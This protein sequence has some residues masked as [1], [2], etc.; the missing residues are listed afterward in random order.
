MCRFVVYKGPKVL[1][2]SI[3]HD[4][5]HSIVNQSKNGGYHPGCIDKS[6]ERN[7]QV[8][9][10]GF[11]V[12]W[13]SYDAR[14]I[15]TATSMAAIKMAGGGGAAAAELLAEKPRSACVFRSTAP[16]WAN[17]NLRALVRHIDSGLIFAHVRAVHMN[18]AKSKNDISED[19]CHPFTHGRYTLMH[20]GCIAGFGGWKRAM[21]RILP[22][23]IYD[24]INGN[25][26]SEHAF[27]LLLD[28]IGADGN[29]ER[30]LTAGEFASALER[31]INRITAMSIENG[32]TEASS[33]NF[34]VTDGRHVI[35]TRCRNQ[36]GE[37]PPSLFYCLGEDCGGCG[38][39]QGSVIISSEP[40]TRDEGKWALVPSNHMI[41]VPFEDTRP[42]FVSSVIIR[43]LVV[44]DINPGK[45][46][47]ID[48]EV[49]EEG[50]EKERP[51]PRNQR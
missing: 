45:V 8:N 10:D 27:A 43:P 19:N 13:Y 38:G 17:H 14:R 48:D 36:T 6:R 46:V 39:N 37:T 1:L 18:N 24:S 3:T 5:E 25:T 40:L 51:D 41:V 21:R 12:A 11:G 15:K 42:N 20:N 2:S 31:T 23:S 33:L 4:P 49:V 28:E 44:D 22:D 30:E 29:L 16:A 9:G 35:A 7:L 50:R 32:V 34:A 47:P 26:D